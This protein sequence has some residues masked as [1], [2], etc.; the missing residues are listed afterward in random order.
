VAV[1]VN[2]KREVNAQGKVTTRALTEDEKTQI[3]NLVKEAMGFNKERGDSLN[4]TNSVFA[5]APKE[6]IPEEPFWKPY[7]NLG[8]AKLAGQYALSAAVLLYLFFGVLRPLLKRA[9]TLPPPAPARAAS[10]SDAPGAEAPRAP[11][12]GG[13][14]ENLQNAKTM[15]AQEPKVVANVVKNWVNGN[16]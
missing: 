12:G 3:S 1:L 15:A 9:T 13:Y 8:T 5:E 2:H 11:V 10:E 4:V 14:A 6:I 16:E 7:A